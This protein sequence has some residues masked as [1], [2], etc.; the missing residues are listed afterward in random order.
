MIMEDLKKPA[1]MGKKIFKLLEK[2]ELLLLQDKAFPNIVTEITGEKIVGSWWGHP[3]ANPIYNGLQWVEHHQP[4]LIIKL[5]DGKVT[6]VHKNLFADI[7]SIV[8]QSR[9]WQMKKLKDDDLQILK[10]ILKNKNITSDDS[11]LVKLV[12]DPKKS[13]VNLE[14]KLLVYSTEEHMD[15]G[16]HIKEYMSWEKSKIAI[17]KPNDYLASKERIENRL[18]SLNKKFGAKAKLPWQ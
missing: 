15:S 10:Y 14:K 8:C 12:K 7:Y 3:L 1:V 9:D 2:Y 5:I 4:I 16:K 6:Y 17:P 11:V 13:F 18:A